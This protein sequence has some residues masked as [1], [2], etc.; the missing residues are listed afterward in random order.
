MRRRRLPPL[1]ALRAFEAAARHLSFRRAAAELG[2]TPTAISHQ[3]RLLEASL[4]LALFVR[5]V[6][7]VA[8]TAAGQRL[9]PALRDGFDAFER[10]LA[11]VS[12]QTG[13]K[14]VTLTATTLFTARRLL[15]A[16]GAFR[17]QHP[18]FDLRLHASDDL[19]DLA[20]GLADIAVRYGSGPFAGL[21]TEPLLSERFGVLCNPSLGL[22]A[23]EDLKRVPLLH[24]EWKRPDMAPDWRR[25]ARLAG[26]TALA[27]DAG[28]RLTDDGYALQAAVA[29]HGVVVASLVLAKPELEA[30]LLVHPF[31]PEIAG[32]AYHVVA[33]PENMAGAD[34]IAVRDWLRAVVRGA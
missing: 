19:V 20:A 3:I 4:G 16:L 29:G 1:A 10:G 12:R 23:H 32:E 22:S 9:Y 18:S 28:P 33:T 21:V 17:A 7:R 26:L 13:R 25:W 24:V 2:V 5:E 27:V 30:G 14:A 11:D 15:P 8:L 31:G 34:V 6:R